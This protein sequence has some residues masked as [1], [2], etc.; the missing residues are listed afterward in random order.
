MKKSFSRLGYSRRAFTLIELLV[1][2][3][4]IGILAAM[5]LPA[6][7]KA[8]ERAL[9]ARARTEMK[10]IEGAINQYHA[11]YSRYPAS[12]L[13]YDSLDPAT[14]PDFTYGTTI[15][16]NAIAP[17]VTVDGKNGAPAPIIQNLSTKGDYQMCNAEVMAILM[18]IEK[19]PVNGGATCNFGFAR[20]PR[21]L[22]LLNAKRVSG[23]AAGGVGDDLVYRDPW[24]NPYIITMDLNGNDKCLDG[25][26]RR[27]TVS[28]DSGVK[29][30]NGL[31]NNSGVGTSDYYELNSPV[32][33]WSL[34]PDAL[35]D[36][37]V[38]AN[39]EQ[40]VLIGGNSVKVS[41]KDNVLTW[42]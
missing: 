21:Q 2:I 6:L 23:T 15:R 34:G 41:N 9:V 7:S 35:A 12:Q 33:V 32:M 38:P 1:V 17:I 30:F 16:T 29:G 5:L 24:G 14:N 22:V 3:S 36:T 13:T 8:K 39:A 40:T 31:Y 25:F 27:A 42:K 18:N 4:I 28:Q 11:E 10:G 37:R 20:N 26:Y 19:Y